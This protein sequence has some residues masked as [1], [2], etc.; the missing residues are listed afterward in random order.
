MAAAANHSHRAGKLKQQNKKNKRSASSK[1]ALNRRQ[2]GKVQSLG[3]VGGGGRRRGVKCN[4]V[5]GKNK[6][7][8]ANA[9]KQRREASRAKA[10]SARRGLLASTASGAASGTGGGI[11]PSRAA[12]SR[13]PPRVV[14]IVS[15][16]ESEGAL[17]ERVREALAGAA[18]RVL[19]S[20]SGGPHG[21]PASVTASYPAHSKG[22]LPHVS[23]LTNAAA[24]VPQYAQEKYRE[25]DASVQGALDLCRVC[26]LV[27]FLID[28][29][30]VVASADASH[31]SS[32]GR[33]GSRAS[34]GGSVAGSVKT[35]AT[36]AHLDHLISERGDRVLT[37]IKSQGLPTPLTVVVHRE[38]GGDSF[39]SDDP[40]GKHVGVDGADVDMEAEVDPEDD[41]DEDDEE[42]EFAEEMNDAAASL[43]SR[44]S[45]GSSRS[46]KSLRRSYLKRRAELKRYAGRFAAT[47]FGEGTKVLELDWAPREG[48]GDSEVTSEGGAT[49]DASA[50]TGGSKSAAGTA[51]STT[52]PKT[53]VAALVRTVCTTSA[54]GPGWVADAPRPYLLSDGTGADVSSRSSVPPVRYDAIKRELQLTGYIRGTTPWDC[55]RL[56]HVPHAGTFAVKDV[57]LAGA[58]SGAG[59]GKGGATELLPPIVAAGRKRRGTAKASDADMDDADAPSG[60]DRG[61]VLLAEPDPEERESLERFASPDALEGEQNLVGFDERD[62]DEDVDDVDDNDDGGADADDDD[63]FEPGTARPAGW[64]DYQSAW[65][66]ALDPDADDAEDRGELAFALNKKKSH[67]RDAAHDDDDDDLAASAE[68]EAALL[69]ARK[70]DREDDLQFPDEAKYEEDTSARDRYARYRAL[71][72]FRRSPWDPKE[73]LPESYGTI[74]HFGSFRAAQRDALEDA[75]ELGEV[76]KRRGWGAGLGRGE[77]GDGDDAAM[78]DDDED[79]DDEEERAAAR[80]CVPPGAYVTLTLAH[81]PPEAFAR[82]SPRSLVAAVSL[83]PHENK[84]SVMHAGLSCSAKSEHDPEVPVKSKDVLTFRCG[85]R[86]WRGRP[87]FSQRNLN[88]DKHKFERFMPSQG[89]AFFAGSVFGPTTYGPCPT[90]VFREGSDEG[91]TSDDGDGRSGTREL[92]AHGSTLGADADRIV[93]KRIVLTGYPTRVH[94]RHATVKYMFYN[95]EDVRWFMPASITT[96]HGLQGNI[97]QSVGD[98]GSMKC[99]FNAPIKQHDTVC[100][101]LYKRLFPK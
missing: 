34:A 37:A 60:S 62:E 70:K 28:G 81:V 38:D 89:G 19:S 32:G 77:K 83:L 29:S 13:A 61:V 68:E 74:Y 26:D 6:A 33:W 11:D 57:T 51:I 17:E 97:V 9:A 66:D 27:L 22:G 45:L 101:P 21:S 82:L 41:D 91:G 30:S 2:G 59:C 76:V 24:F 53:S 23:L 49:D 56:V 7:D 4:D 20:S 95:P 80:A 40:L 87:V 69:A 100:L 55:H 36:T 12:P 43:L 50:A 85:W 98:H 75:R 96:K 92:L 79:S 16:S 65:L 90:L 14:G 64:S 99:L 86:T 58:S 44:R 3:G 18:D 1:R 84:V 8:R 10:R 25:E 72:S 47:E 94:K 5:S 71:K 15:L 42:D 46:A 73:N 54:Q 39:A 35:G 48:G 78:D 93:L 67:E 88:A 63:K 52:S 31:A